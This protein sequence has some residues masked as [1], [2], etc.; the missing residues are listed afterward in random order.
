MAISQHFYPEMAP[1]YYHPLKA[2]VNTNPS[3]GLSRLKGLVSLRT[4]CINFL[5]DTFGYNPLRFY[6]KNPEKYANNWQFK[7][8]EVIMQ[9]KTRGLVNVALI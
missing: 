9:A 3:V 1:E 5:T 8:I 7:N 4:S 2:Y 6:S